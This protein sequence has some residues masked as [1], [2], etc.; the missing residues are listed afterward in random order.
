[1]C[2]FSSF[3]HRVM[4]AVS[5]KRDEIMVA[6]PDATAGVFLKVLCP[7]LLKT[8]LRKRAVTH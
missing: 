4:Q 8:I 1:M 3:A 2:F 5:E 6:K 7:S